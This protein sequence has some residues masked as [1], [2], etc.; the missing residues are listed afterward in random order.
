M[1]SV[2]Q[3]VENLWSLTPTRRPYRACWRHQLLR[4]TLAGCLPSYDS[5]AFE[6]S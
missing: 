2:K 6:F 4:L 3:V 5:C 1:P